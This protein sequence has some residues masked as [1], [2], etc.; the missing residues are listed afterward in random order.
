MF[1]FQGATRPTDAICAHQ[2]VQKSRPQT[3]QPEVA[4]S[5]QLETDR[6]ILTISGR[7]DGVYSQPDRIIIEEIKTTSRAPDYYEQHEVP[8]SW[9]NTRP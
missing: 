8:L 7:M 5:H 9:P 4:I 2:K 6:F 1:E 3:Y